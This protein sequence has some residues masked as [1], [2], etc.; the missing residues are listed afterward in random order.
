MRT[1][2]EIAEGEYI[3]YRR[4]LSVKQI[5]RGE[6]DYVV[7]LMNGDQIRFSNRKTF[8]RLKN[9]VTMGHPVVDEV[10]PPRRNEVRGYEQ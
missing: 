7:K 10:P 6:D 8:E 4:V 2:I 5:V 3:P 9:Y 1:G